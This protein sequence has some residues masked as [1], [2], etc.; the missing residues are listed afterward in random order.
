M[1]LQN[2]VLVFL[3]ERVRIVGKKFFYS[4]K[5][6]LKIEAFFFIKI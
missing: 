3:L 5:K 1:R 2:Q 6:G 4:I